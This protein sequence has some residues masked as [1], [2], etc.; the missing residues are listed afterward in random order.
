DDASALLAKCT[1]IAMAADSKVA[2][3]G[4][5][6]EA[7]RQLEQ[8]GTVNAVDAKALTVWAASRGVQLEPG[9]DPLLMAY[10]LDPSVA[11]PLS[12]VQHFGA[13]SWADDARTRA[14][15][16]AELLRRVP[17]RLTGPVSSVYETIEKPLQRVL[18]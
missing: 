13:G 12:A 14:I 16:T 15:A 7:L 11:Q 5:Q 3:A 9:D 6:A 18:A 17:E 10:V 8:L 1:G 4:D 2:V